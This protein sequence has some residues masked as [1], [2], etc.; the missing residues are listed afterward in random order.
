MKE[1]FISAYLIFILLSFNQKIYAQKG[2]GI[3]S[4][5]FLKEQIPVIAHI[6]EDST[7][8]VTVLAK[9][10]NSEP[11]SP[12]L[13]GYLFEMGYGDMESGL[14]AEMI[15]NRQFEPFPPYKP[16]R[17]WWYGLRKRGK[18]KNYS[19][20]NLTD[21]REM[22]WYHSGYEHNSWYAAPDRI[23][24]HHIDEFTTLF[25]L[26][27]ED[28]TAEIELLTENGLSGQFA[29]VKN[30]SETNRTGIAQNGMYLRKHV[31]CTFKGYFRN[32]D[33][34]NEVTVSFYPPDEWEKPIASVVIDK[35]EKKWQQREIHF[36]G[37]EYEG[38]ATLMISLKANSVVDMDALSLMPDDAVNGW[39]KDV[40][41]MVRD[42]IKPGMLR[43]PGGC[44]ASYYQWKDGIGNLDER[45]VRVSGHWGG[46]A[47]NDVG[48]LEYLDFC[49]NTGAEPFICLNMFHPKKEK[50]SYYSPVEEKW[51]LHGYHF[52][53]I[54]DLEKGAR[55]AAEWVAYCNL[56]SGSHPMADLREKHGQKAPGNVKYWELE[57]EAWRWFATAEEYAN[58]CVVYAKAMKAVDP[59]I[60]LGI[61]TYGKQLSDGLNT[62]LQIAGKYIDFL[63]D[64]GTTKENI[65]RKTEMIRDFNLQHHTH[66]KYAN[67][68]YLVSSYDPATINALKK[69]DIWEGKG[70]NLETATWGYALS[71]ANLLMQW[72]RYGGEVIFTCFNSFANDHLNSVI[73]TPKE[74]S[75]LKYPAAI[76]KL[77]RETPARWL[78]N[79][80]GYEMDIGK[81]T[82]VQVA[83]DEGKENLVVYHLNS[84]PYPMKAIFNL[85]ELGKSF[86]YSKATYL[87]G[88]ALETIRSVKQPSLTVDVKTVLKEIVLKNGI[89]VSV[90]PP[91]SLL[92]IEL[93]ENPFDEN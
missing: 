21:W 45:P 12:L 92:Q 25:Q 84:N 11:I 61:C 58:S 70:R 32:I 91:W 74:G 31:P 62:V 52:P 56:P 73:E 59:D 29:R 4:S 19:D 42:S 88:P 14:W 77:F 18:E 78:L 87:T 53:E 81:S 47:Y 28:H 89:W 22:D 16:G 57:N 40:V 63:A 83:W 41:E 34:K 33:G 5:V 55:L 8:H 30:L 23:D 85:N 51:D 66:I 2:A 39:R 65:D 20:L 48:T 68:E 9:E 75:F 44:Y 72:Q 43:W 10:L 6:S 79:L 50:Y 54:T 13:P 76:G 82:Q 17:D 64:R 71:W 38:F 60:Q 36:R 27:N 26:K 90:V 24:D 69:Y 93:S 37:M 15:F 35:L 46:F 1:L 67:T 86:K 7:L 49:K 3:D 80:Q